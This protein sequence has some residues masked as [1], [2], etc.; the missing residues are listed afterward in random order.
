M[1]QNR[2]LKRKL[3]EAQ[4]GKG[5]RKLKQVMLEGGRDQ[6][7]LITTD[8]E[9]LTLSGIG[10]DIMPVRVRLSDPN[11]EKISCVRLMKK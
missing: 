1:K 4:E 10:W 2:K 7:M 9:W 3:R 5:K 8:G 11:E 6:R